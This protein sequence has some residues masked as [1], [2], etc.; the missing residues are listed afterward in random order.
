MNKNY[1]VY[2][3][4]DTRKPGQNLSCRFGSLNF[5]PF[6]IGKGLKG[7]PQEHLRNYKKK[8]NHKNKTIEAI[9]RSGLLPGIVTIFKDLTESEAY[10]AE[11]KV[12]NEIGLKN[13]TNVCQGGVGRDSDSMKGPKNPTFGTK[14]PRWIIEKMQAARNPGHERI[15]KTLEEILGTEAARQSRLK[16]S[17]AKKGRTWDDYYGKEKSALLKEKRR[18]I[19]LGYKHSED[20]KQKM[21]SS[22]KARWAKQ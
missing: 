11:K 2:A 1:F 7:R 14:R 12:I 9:Y 19:R 4:L 18:Q 16:M 22:A 17:L 10:L 6:Y 13:L 15:G 5:K 3:L 20:T 21:R 8:N